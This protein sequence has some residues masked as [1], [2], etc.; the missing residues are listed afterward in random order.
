[1]R[2]LCFVC[3]TPRSGS[4]LLTN[5]LS[6]NPGAHATATSGLLDTLRAV[7]DVCDQ[8]TFFK[9]MTSEDRKARKLTLLRGVVDGYFADQAGKVCFDKSRGWPTSFELAAWVLGGRENVK[10]IVCVRDVRDVLASFEKLYRATA[11]VSATSQE[12]AAFVEHRTAEGRAKFILR[13]DEPFGYAM[14][15]VRDAVT[16][17]WRDNMLFVEYDKLCRE[18]HK[19]TQMIYGFIGEESFGHD[20]E[21]VEQVTRENDEVF[22]FVGLHDIRP[23]IQP[24]EPQ[25]PL[26]YDGAM[27][28]TN[29]WSRVTEGAR[30]WEHMR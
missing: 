25:W 24:Q 30:Y 14:D 19:T 18:P 27:T 8:N 1:M 4:T 22:G 20:V 17:G 16:R 29:F 7:R 3:G 23:K 10:A 9:A 21:N 2:K 26:V 5:L 28:Q 11:E 13:K 15:V 12:R 6:Q